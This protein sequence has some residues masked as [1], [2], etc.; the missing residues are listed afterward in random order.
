FKFLIIHFKE[1][2]CSKCIV[3]LLKTESSSTQDRYARNALDFSSSSSNT[4]VHL[5]LEVL[6]AFFRRETIRRSQKFA[7]ADLIT[8][9][10]HVHHGGSF[11]RGGRI[12][13]C[14]SAR[15]GR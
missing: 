9:P 10:L 11:H 4:F 8:L 7:S 6:V 12:H 13:L 5:P 15:R 14:P 2:I 1:N 3:E